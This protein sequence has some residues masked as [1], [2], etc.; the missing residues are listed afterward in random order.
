MLNGYL[1]AKEAADKWNIT[2]RQVQILCKTNR[3]NGAVLASRVWLIPENAVKPTADRKK[4]TR[5]EN[6]STMLGGDSE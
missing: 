3:I 1:T 5:T 6:I 4:G 2:P